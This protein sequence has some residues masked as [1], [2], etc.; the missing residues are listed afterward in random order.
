LRLKRWLVEL[1]SVTSLG[2][3]TCNTDNRWYPET[4]QYNPNYIIGDAQHGTVAAP[5]GDIRAS[6][7]LTQLLADNPELCPG[8]TELMLDNCYTDGKSL[9]D[10]VRKRKAM[11]DC[12][13]IQRLEMWSCTQL[14]KKAFN[15]LVNEVP[16]VKLGGGHFKCKCG[17]HQNDDFDFDTPPDGM[18]ELPTD[19]FG[20]QDI[21]S[22]S[23]P[24]SM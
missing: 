11:K 12:A 19:V 15:A 18:R 10:Y 23:C 14:S 3:H 9:V 1:D 4:E 5:F 2:L 16:V 8:L 13:N 21:F 17:R 6:I 24:T 22:E 20:C 7:R